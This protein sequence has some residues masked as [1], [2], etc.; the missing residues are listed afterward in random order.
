[1]SER[2]AAEAL[3]VKRGFLRLAIQNETKIRAEV[4]EQ[5][6]NNRKRHRTGKNEDVEN[7]MYDWYKFA[8]L[9]GVTVNGPILRQKSEQLAQ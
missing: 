6:G 1:M 2:K 3:K 8:N 7:G 5:R 9:R 4:A